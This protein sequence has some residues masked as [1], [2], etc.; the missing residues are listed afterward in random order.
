M[1]KL[2]LRAMGCQLSPPFQCSSMLNS[3]KPVVRSWW[4][5]SVHQT[6]WGQPSRRLSRPVVWSIWLSSR[7]MARMPVSRRARAGCSGAKPAS[8][9]RMSGEAL[10]RIQFTPSSD[11]AM[12]DWVRAWALRVP[13]RKPSQLT[14]LQFHW[15]KPPPAAEPR[16][17]ICMGKAK[18]GKSTP[19]RTGAWGASTVGEVHG[20]FEADA[21]VSVSRLGPHGRSPLLTAKAGR[22]RSSSLTNVT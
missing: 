20:D 22:I 7:T 8:W 15:G 10:H 9:A 3:G 12:E 19:R 16:I 1:V 21:Q 17:W 11:R 18:P 2:P 13:L 6:S 4:T 5:I 14:Q